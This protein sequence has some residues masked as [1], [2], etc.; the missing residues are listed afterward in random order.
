VLALVAAGGCGGDGGGGE[1]SS[2]KS[3]DQWATTVCG[4]LDDWGTSL[5]AGSQELAPALQQRKN[6]ENSK[7]RFIAFL[8]EAEKDTQ[9]LV[10]EV[11]SA[12][13]PQTDEGEA[14]QRQLVSALEKM[15]ESFASAIDRAKELETTGLQSFRS[16]VGA[17]STEVQT[18]LQ[19]AGA[20]FNRIGE[21]STEIEEAIDTNPSC[22]QFADAG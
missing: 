11:E 22:Q 18:N 9:A 19:A 17:I 20:F 13:S 10:N 16:G 8:E 15:Q 12:G 21:R 14:L 6:L 4:A 3:P 1:N 2:S 7:E 5:Q